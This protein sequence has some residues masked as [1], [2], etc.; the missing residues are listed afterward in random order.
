MYLSAT[1]DAIQAVQ[2]AAAT[3]TNCTYNVAYQDWTSSGLDFTTITGAS[4]DLNGMTDATIVAA[5]SGSNK[6]QV[7]EIN[8]YNADTI[9][10]TVT[11]LRD[12]SATNKILCKAQL[13]VGATLFWSKETGWTILSASTTNSYIVTEF[14]ASGTWTK[15]TGLKWAEILC[16]GAG[17]AGGSGMRGA[18]ATNRFGG[19]GG[20]GGAMVHRLMTAGELPATVTVTVGTGGTGGTAQTVDSTNGNAGTAGTDTSFGALVIAKG[21]SGGSGGTALT[22]T[23][24][25]GGTAQFSTPSYGPFAVSGAGGGSG[26]TTAASS[27]SSGLAGNSGGPSGA[28]GQGINSS[29]TSG[30]GTISGGS[31]C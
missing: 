24:G 2:G 25:A 15:P 7:T 6:R 30:T 17:G 4:G 22:G 18:A 9:V 23:A 29:N 8:I 27:G 13:A 14:T 19:G 20:G 21:G 31:H 3:T 1:T 16:I 5:P 12:V 28:G 26:Q 10:Q 11:V